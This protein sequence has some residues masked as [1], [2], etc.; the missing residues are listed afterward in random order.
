MDEPR[1]EPGFSGTAAAGIVG[2][3]YRQL[4]Y[5]AR[6]NLVRPSLADA[7]GS[8]SRRKYSYRDLLELRVIKT[9]LDA[10]I[11]LESVRTAFGYLRLHSD[12]S[13]ATLVING[14]DVVL[15]DGDELISVL[16]GGQGMLNV[17]ALDGVKRQLDEQ[18]VQLDD[19]PPTRRRAI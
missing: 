4:D 9:M 17:L 3:S 5:W 13:S 16:R 10:G 11:K 2:I 1:Q 19:A 15:C 7:S 12:I 14:S 18:I 6:T 8:G